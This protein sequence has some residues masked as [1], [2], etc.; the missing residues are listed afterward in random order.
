MTG[1][2]FIP[3]IIVIIVV[4]KTRKLI[5]RFR[6][7]GAIN[8]ENAK[9]LDELK[10]SRRLIFRKYFSHSVIIETHGKYY[11]DEQNLINYRTKK[12]MILIPLVVIFMIIILYLDIT[13]T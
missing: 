12:R 4:T 7:F 6:N 13:L 3:I 10:L 2:S 5:N 11:L 9:T 1:T 8:E